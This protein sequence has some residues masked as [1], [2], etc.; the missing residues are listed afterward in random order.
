MRVHV[1]FP[2]HSRVVVNFAKTDSLKSFGSR[3]LAQ[4]PTE[5]LRSPALWDSHYASWI[6]IASQ[7]QPSAYAATPAL[8]RCCCFPRRAPG[9]V[10]L[11]RP[12]SD[13]TLMASGGLFPCLRSVLDLEGS[14]PVPFNDDDHIEI[15]QGAPLCAPQP[16]QIVEVDP[17]TRQFVLNEDRLQSILLAREVSHLPAVV[18]SIAGPFRGGK[19]FMLNFF[20]QYLQSTVR[21]RALPCCRSGNPDGVSCTQGSGA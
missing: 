12:H 2:G 7:G 20:I 6:D 17:A 8:A 18:I 4:A 3:V 16:L 13:P 1:Q 11:P 5:A 21:C 19:S 9:L 10:R 15:L 14:S